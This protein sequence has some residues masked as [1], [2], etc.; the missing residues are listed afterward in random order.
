MTIP[1]ERTM[2]ISRTRDFLMELLDPKETPD[3]PKVIR[4]RARSLLKHYPGDWELR[5]V[6]EKAPNVFGDPATF[7][8]SKD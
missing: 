3:I 2:T 8:E 1:L 7:F 5:Q 6:V 4:Q